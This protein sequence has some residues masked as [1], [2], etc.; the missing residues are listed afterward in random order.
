[1]KLRIINNR[2]FLILD[3][4]E[5]LPNPFA[6][7][8]MEKDTIVKSH[9]DVILLRDLDYSKYT[10][11]YGDIELE[12]DVL[13]RRMNNLKTIHISSRNRVVEE[14]LDKINYYKSILSRMTTLMRE[15]KIDEVLKKESD[16]D[17]VWLAC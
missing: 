9:D 4:L 15:N 16:Y 10:M 11:S 7:D 6:K 8:G 12:I 5:G 17:T 1:M 14:C 2:S 13:F 3:E